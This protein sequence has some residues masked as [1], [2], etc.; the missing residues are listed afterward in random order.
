MSLGH[1]WHLLWSRGTKPEPLGCT[2]GMRAFFVFLL[3]FLHKSAAYAMTPL[4][5]KVV[6]ME[7]MN[8]KWTLVIRIFWNYVDGFIFLSAVTTAFNAAQQL[9]NGK[10]LNILK[11]YIRRYIR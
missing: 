1:N 3:Y 9:K 5:N 2:H 10:N 8:Q 11:M 7:V 6:G 4:T